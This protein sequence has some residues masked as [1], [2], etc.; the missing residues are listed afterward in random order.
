MTFNLPMTLDE[1]FQQNKG[2]AILIPDG[3][4]GNNGQCAQWSSYV[5]HN[6]Y[7]F[8]YFYTPNASDWFYKAATLGITQHFNV[9]PR[10]QV[11]AIPKGA[12]VVYGP[13]SATDAPGH[14]DVC[15][16]DGGKLSDFWAYDSNWSAATF[17]DANGYPTLHE[18]HHNDNFNA[19]IIGILVLKENN[20]DANGNVT[21]TGARALLTLSTLMAQ[22]G[23]APDRQPTIQ[24]VENLIGRNLVDAVNSL[25]STAPWGGN[26]N[27]VKHYDEDVAAAKAGAGGVTKASVIAYVQ[28]KLQ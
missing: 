12:F 8:P 22:P 17:H 18:V 3:G 2:T 13:L 7:D 28:A 6:V 21:D 26:W 15:S 11:T 14:I 10:A 1:A 24:E 25:T 20:M 16:R 27:K 23:L 9:I 5:W 19:K 4:A